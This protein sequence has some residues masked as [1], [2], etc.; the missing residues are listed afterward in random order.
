MKVIWVLIFILFMLIW[1]F[2]FFYVVEYRLTACLLF[3]ALIS[4]VCLYFINLGFLAFC[5]YIGAAAGVVVLVSYCIALIPFSYKNG[6]K[7]WY[8]LFR[9][10]SGLRIVRKLSFFFFVFLF[11]QFILVFLKSWLNGDIGP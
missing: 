2:S 1:Y 10:A 6:K 8:S 4:S 7:K 11:F 9:F 3:S 5:L